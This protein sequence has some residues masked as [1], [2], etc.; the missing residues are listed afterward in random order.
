MEDTLE[1]SYR[2]AQ[3]EHLIVKS[4]LVKCILPYIY[5]SSFNLEIIY[6]KK[7]K[8]TLAGSRGILANLCIYKKPKLKRFL[9]CSKYFENEVNR[10]LSVCNHF[11]SLQLQFEYHGYS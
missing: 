6:N 2:N 10:L 4:L 3:I 11:F 5:F 7:V 8:S 9:S 1:M